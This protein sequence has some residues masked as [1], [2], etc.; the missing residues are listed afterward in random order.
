MSESDSKSSKWALAWSALGVH[1]PDADLYKELLARY[2]E[3]HRAYHTLQHQDECLLNFNELL[4]QAEHSAEISLAIWFHDAIYDIGRSDNEERSASWAHAALL[5]AGVAEAVADRVYA[6]IMAT[7]HDAVPHGVDAQILIDVDLWVLGSPAARF[8]EYER[9]IR[10]E[11]CVVPE[12]IFQQK[13]LQILQY[14]FDRPRIF[15]TPVFFERH[16]H[17]A[18]QNLLRSIQCLKNVC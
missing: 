18:K 16:E 7:R 1:Q 15:S 5:K 8:D 3:P 10:Q 13:R 17:Q 4:A 6:L 11:Y 9:Q 2:S 14:F 12:A